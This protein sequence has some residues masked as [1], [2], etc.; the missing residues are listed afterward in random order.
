[1][2]IPTNRAV[3]M[4][5]ARVNMYCTSSYGF[6][7]I[8]WGYIPV[9]GPP[10]SIPISFGGSN[11]ASGHTQFYAVEQSSGSEQSSLIILSA[12]TSRA[13]TYICAEGATQTASAQLIV[14]SKCIHLLLQCYDVL[15]LGSDGDIMVY[16]TNKAVL[17]GTVNA[18]MSCASS[19][20]YSFIAWSYIPVGTSS[21]V[22]ISS[23]STVV[24]Q[25]QQSYAV[26]P[27][28]SNQIKL[29]ILSATPSR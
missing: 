15:H 11:V 29:I 14:I 2:M 26:Q 10:P 9:G 19:F 5:S 25:Q 13:G 20:G 12:T 24:Q 18:T 4:G 3:L 21:V 17:F 28:G 22:T 7:A 8:S 16:P 6:Q 27:S 23:G 1:M